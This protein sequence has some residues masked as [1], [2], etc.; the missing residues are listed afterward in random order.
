MN[1]GKTSLLSLFATLL[2]YSLPTQV[3]CAQLSQPDGGNLLLA[4]ECNLT[5]IQRS[6]AVVVLILIA[7]E[8]RVHHALRACTSQEHRRIPWVCFEIA[9]AMEIGGIVD[10]SGPV[11]A[12]SLRIGAQAAAPVFPSIPA[13]SNSHPL[14][15][16]P[17]Q[18]KFKSLPLGITAMQPS[19]KR[20]SC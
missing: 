10:V 19:P 17:R 9:G 7:G 16:K 15:R 12:R 20:R 1:L 6:L 14:C 3:L 5:A 8:N 13:G 4:R 11:I 2:I 18:G